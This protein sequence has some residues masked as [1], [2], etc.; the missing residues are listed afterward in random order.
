MKICRN[1]LQLV[2][3]FDNR[4]SSTEWAVQ[5]TT[6]P[7]SFRYITFRLQASY[8]SAT[9]HTGRKSCRVKSLYIKRFWLVHGACPLLDTLVGSAQY[10]PHT[11]FQFF[12][13]P[14]PSK[15]G[16][17]PWW[18]ACLLVDVSGGATKRKCPT[19]GGREQ[20]DTRS[21]ISFWLCVCISWVKLGC[22]SVNVWQYNLLFVYHRLIVHVNQFH[23][24]V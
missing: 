13:S 16:R 20:G 21:I 17:Q 19:C 14:S 24:L 22:I 6:T 8:L 9:S 3:T 7:Q 5:C 1:R 4:F 2:F 11:L 18:T 12:V 23:P 15:L 10:F